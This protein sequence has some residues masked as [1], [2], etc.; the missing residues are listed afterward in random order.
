MPTPQNFLCSFR[1]L[2]ASKQ[3]QEAVQNH[4]LKPFVDASC[5]REPDFEAQFPSISALCRKEYFAPRLRVGSKV[6]YITKKGRYLGS[7][8]NHWR[9]VAVLEV[10]TSFQSHAEAANWYIQNGECLPSNC[11]VNGNPA[12]PLD[13]TDGFHSDI[14]HW[15]AIYRL[16]AKQCGVFHICSKELYC[17]LENPPIVTEQMMIEVFGYIPATRNPPSI[18]ENAVSRFLEIANEWRRYD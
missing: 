1:P 16:R 14:R 13:K 15:D 17:E 3:G 6:V 12:M 7:T 9:L 5:R 8:D 18:S 4:R 2:V 10:T 11:M